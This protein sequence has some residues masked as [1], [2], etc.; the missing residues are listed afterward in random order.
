[1]DINVIQRIMKLNIICFNFETK[2]GNE[3]CDNMQYI[4]NWLTCNILVQTSD[5]GQ[6]VGGTNSGHVSLI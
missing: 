6:E 5:F 4:T 2:D 3:T 1:M